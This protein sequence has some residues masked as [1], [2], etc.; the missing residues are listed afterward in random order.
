MNVRDPQVTS[1]QIIKG[2]AVYSKLAL[3]FYD[4]TVLNI[5]NNYIWKCPS[6]H[7]QALYQKYASNNH[8]EVGVGTGYF[9]QNCRFEKP[10]RIALMDLNQNCLD[11][12]AKRLA[13][14]KPEQYKRNIYEPVGLSVPLF[15]SL[16]INYVLHCLPGDL[17]TK[18]IVFGH[19]K[20]LLNPKAVVFGSTILG[21]GIR[22]N[23]MA[24]MITKTY[25]SKG[26]FSNLQDDFDGLKVILEKNFSSCHVEVIGCVALFWARV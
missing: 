21:K 5:S 13:V 25:N 4:L 19:L 24:Q 15:D 26:I 23:P 16:G 9:L 22:L 6:S 2:Q 7:I 14:Y 3:N 20:V 17:H 8:L 10:P 11:E 12:T 1:E 18:A